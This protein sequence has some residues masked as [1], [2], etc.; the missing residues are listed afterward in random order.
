MMGCIM[1]GLGKMEA[2][3]N[4]FKM[5]EQWSSA[6]DMIMHFLM[7]WVASSFQGI[8]FIISLYVK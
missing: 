4:W 1:V 8:F 7:V 5:R 6:V 3:L 2:E